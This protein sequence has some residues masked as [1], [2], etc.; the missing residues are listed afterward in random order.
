MESV[1][2][3]RLYDASLVGVPF[4]IFK[5]AAGWT[6]SAN[7][8]PLAGQLV[9]LWGV[10]DVLLNLAAMVGGRHAYCL[11]AMIGRWLDGRRGDHWE[12]R[13]LALDTF[14]SFGIV[15][16]MIWF[17]FLPA[18]PRLLGRTWDLAVIGNVMGVGAERL[19][20]ALR[21]PRS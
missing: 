17:R 1:S 12:E 5:V 9:M 21:Q 6:M 4:G 11:L 3:R 15:S 10:I 20:N 2:R 8:L 16:G 14:L 7:G 19:Y 13:L 18:L